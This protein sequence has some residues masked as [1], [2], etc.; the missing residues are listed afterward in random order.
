MG[1]FEFCVLELFSSS[2]GGL[3]SL[4]TTLEVGYKVMTNF[5]TILSSR[6]SDLSASL[7][8]T[9]SCL[10][11][12]IKYIATYNH[13]HKK[14]HNVL[15]KFMILCW[16]AFVAILGRVRAVGWTPWKALG[17]CGVVNG[18]IFHSTLN[19][20]DKGRRGTQRP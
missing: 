7:G 15:S 17:L 11:P 18:G 1:Y 13:T 16:A 9:E 14:P 8:H 5:F 19:G 10:G 6:V 3:A 2:L 20:H 4:V 12:Q